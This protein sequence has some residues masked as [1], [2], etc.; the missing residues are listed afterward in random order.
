MELMADNTILPGTGDV[1]AADD[2]SGVKFQRVK[3]I[4]GAD[5]VNDGDVSAAGGFPVRSYGGVISSNNSSTS[6]LAGDAVFTGTGDDIS[7]YTSVSITIKSDKDAAVDGVSF[8]FSSDNSNWD[9]QVTAS[10]DDRG[11][12]SFGMLHKFSPATQFFRVVYT[13]GADAQGHFR[14]QTLFHTDNAL[15]LISRSGQI[16]SPDVDVYTVRPANSF[17]LDLAR[18]HISNQRAFFFFGQNNSVGTSFVD[19]NPQGGD[20]PWPTSGTKVEVLSSDTN[21]T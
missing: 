19:V 3:L 17:D 10:M 20:Y 13:N 2:I 16:I 5:G 6:T 11:G 12:G 1:Y 18:K 15:P 7:H 21:D 14:L 8:Q 9:H 4:H